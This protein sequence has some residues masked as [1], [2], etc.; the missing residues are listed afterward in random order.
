VRVTRSAL[1]ALLADRGLRPRKSLG[2]CFLVDPNFLDALARDTG[3]GPQDGVVEIGSGPGNLTDALAAR[4]GHVWAFEVDEALQGLSRDL[5]ADRNNVTLVHA[6]GAEF[7]RHLPADAGRT[8]RIVSNLPY[9][10]W[11][12][13][14]LAALSTARPVA[15]FTFMVQTDVYERLRA[16]PGSKAYGPVPALLQATSSVKRL[17]AAG[18]ALFLPVP[19]VDSTVF[20][21]VRKE[22]ID[23]VRAEARLRE[24]FSHRRKKSPAADGRRIEELSPSELLRLALPG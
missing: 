7:D 16:A 19:R 2:Q 4:A 20:S 10:D 22:S 1:A 11:Q 6:D 24:L 21:I 3:A 13:L 23:F 14:L 12:R 9:M 15:S 17:R 5:L 18:R 8:L